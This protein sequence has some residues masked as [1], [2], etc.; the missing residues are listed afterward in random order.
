[1][2]ELFGSEH[3]TRPDESEFE[4]SVFGPGHGECIVLHLGKGDWVVVDSHRDTETNEPVALRYL[5]TLGVNVAEHVKMVVAT[6][7]HDDHMDGLGDLFQECASAKFVCTMAMQADEM[8]TLV[9][10]YR[11]QILNVGPGVNEMRKVFD[12]LVARRAA[13]GIPA[14]RFAIADRELLARNDDLPVRI[15]ALAPSDAGIA[16]MLTRIQQKQLPKDARR[17]L[18]VPVLDENDASVVLAVR[19]GSVSVLLGGDLEERKR[20][21]I[22]WQVILDHYPAE[23]ERFDGFKI[24]HHGSITGHHPDVWPRLMHGESWAAVAPFN[25]LENPLPT[26]ADCQRIL[27]TAKYAYISAA[28]G[29]NEYHHDQLG[30]RETE[31]AATLAIA[32]EPGRQGQI[33]LRRRLGD[34]P[35]DWTVELF[36]NAAPLAA[37]LGQN[38]AGGA[39]A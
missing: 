28:P 33:R 26:T 36:G 32:E 27:A 7:W 4:V 15:R 16:T 6:H 17:R 14:P 18:R 24:P 39:A 35:G 5:Q 8:K 13:G 19:V 37:L 25:Q 30:V 20:P 34:N 29:L 23:G 9:E 12:V 2:E 11:G 1:M 21:D 31:L 10:T 22:G 38:P 3:A